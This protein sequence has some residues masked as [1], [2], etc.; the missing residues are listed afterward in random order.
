M[1]TPENVGVL[2]VA[3][4]VERPRPVAVVPTPRRTTTATTARPGGTRRVAPGWELRRRRRTRGEIPVRLRAPRLPPAPRE[5]AGNLGTEYGESRYS[6]VSTTTF[7]RAEG[8]RPRQV[9]TLYYDDLAGLEA[10]GI[11]VRPDP[12]PV[13]WVPSPQPFPESRFAPPPP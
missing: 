4:F 6:P 2:G 8:S 10:R 3:C 12:E 5:G 11:R 13:H 7:E 1:G 9:L